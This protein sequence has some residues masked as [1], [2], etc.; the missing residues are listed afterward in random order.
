MSGRTQ[1]TYLNPEFG[2]R[3]SFCPK[4]N[5]CGPQG[6]RCTYLFLING[7]IVG[8]TGW[9]RVGAG[10]GKPDN[11]IELLSRLLRRIVFS[12]VIENLY[13]IALT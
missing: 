10:D 3:R 1:G 13:R 6:D 8:R 5:Q 11:L 2:P 9:N 7:G 12:R 4:I